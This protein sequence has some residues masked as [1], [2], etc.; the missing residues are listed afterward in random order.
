MTT[1][2]IM[3]QATPAEP[4]PPGR[5]LRRDLEALEVSLPSA[6]RKL[7]LNLSELEALLEG[8]L[9]I[10]PELAARIARAFGGRAELW[11]E[12]Q[13]RFENHPKA[14]G[15]VRDGAGRKRLGLEN[16][17]V[18]LSAKPDEMPLIEAWLNAQESAAQAVAS[19]IL[20]QAK[21]AVR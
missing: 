13:A 11:L 7:R 1:R 15:G 3:N 20:K 12:L 2:R 10:T 21:R 14:R 9:A 19:L 8:E 16:K 4:S 5:V 17:M 18:R 6:A